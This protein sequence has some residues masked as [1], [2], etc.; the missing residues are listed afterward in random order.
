MCKEKITIL[1]LKRYQKG[2]FIMKIIKAEL[3]QRTQEYKFVIDKNKLTIT[4]FGLVFNII[5]NESDMVNTSTIV[6]YKNEKID[7]KEVYEKAKEK[8]NASFE[9]ALD[10]FIDKFS[11]RS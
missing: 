11:S 10:E 2:I 3:N 8:F 5:L 9:K 7:D 4:K 1:Y 6:D